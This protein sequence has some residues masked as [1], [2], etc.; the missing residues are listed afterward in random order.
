[1]KK[2]TTLLTAIIIFLGPVAI[3]QLNKDNLHTPVA[4]GE[5]TAKN[6]FTSQHKKL[7]LYYIKAKPS[8]YREFK[9]MGNYTTLE[10]A[11]K[12]SK[13]KV[14]EISSGGSVN[15]LRF[16]NNS[17]DSILIS[18]GDIVKGGKQD[19]VIEKD[20]L[21]APGK[22]MEIPVY[23]VEH[24]RWSSGGSNYQLSQQPRNIR[25]RNGQQSG[26]NQSGASFNTYHSKINNVV[27]KSI[28]KEKNQGKVWEKVASINQANGTNTSTGTYTAVTQSSTY[29]KDMKEYKDALRKN[30]NSDSSIVGIL[31]V[32]GDH[33]IGCD[34]Y[35][36]PNLFKHN[37][38]NLLDSYIAEAMY[39]GGNVIITDKAVEAYLTKLLQNDT[40]QDKALQNNGR[41]LK[42]NGKKVK[43]TSFDN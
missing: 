19:R 31:A 3:A 5:Q 39:E 24:G 40:E 29:L 1:M 41:S 25:V 8:L 20:T 2:L 30:I 16:S 26:L 12:D 11:I 13:I 43:L 14:Q 35:A 15:T 9:Q 38:N 23:C 32:T 7:K 6:G 10:T 42:V 34:I 33:I 36:T 27:R 22:T 18:M 17:R 4:E 28:V 21:I 37:I